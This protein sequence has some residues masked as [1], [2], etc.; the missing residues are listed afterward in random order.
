MS[1]AQAWVELQSV[2]TQQAAACMAGH[3]QLLAARSGSG[4]QAVA[5]APAWVADTGMPAGGGF[6]PAP[7]FALLFSSREAFPGKRGANAWFFT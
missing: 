1:L 6:S 7:A 2:G 5:A 3:G 4:G